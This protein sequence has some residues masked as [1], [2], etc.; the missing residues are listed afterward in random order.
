M[1]YVLPLILLVAAQPGR[2][3]DILQCTLG[4]SAHGWVAQSLVLAH[5]PGA[6]KAIVADDLGLYYTGKPATA[7]VT[8][9]RGNK[10]RFTW[11]IR[12]MTDI[13]GN[14]VPAMVYR[15]TLSNGQRSL[16][17]SAEPLG[18][19]SRFS[20]S[21]TCQPV[22]EAERRAFEKIVRQSAE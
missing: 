6:A 12:K 9:E 5:E 1:R 17:V 4:E 20:G 19:S 18:Y 3:M 7:R 21:G 14:L 15:A 11:K 16:K 10:L 22:A 8:S 13:R 2:A